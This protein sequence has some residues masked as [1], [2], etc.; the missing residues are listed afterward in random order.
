MNN[1][2]VYQQ[3]LPLSIYSAAELHSQGIDEKMIQVIE[4]NRPALQRWFHDQQLFAVGV[5]NSNNSQN[6]GPGA[7]Q[8]GAI[9]HRL[10]NMGPSPFGAGPSVPQ[11]Q[12]NIAL[13]MNSRPQTKQVLPQ[14]I[15]QQQP[16]GQHLQPSG[17]EGVDAMLVARMQQQQQI[18]LNNYKFAH[19]ISQFKK[20]FVLSGMF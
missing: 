19:L 7:D 17:P 8:N 5:R 16:A 13:A 4:N 14:Q 1:N 20:D 15:V 9:G 12:Q 10:P 3:L 6:M 18:P 2:R 11:Q